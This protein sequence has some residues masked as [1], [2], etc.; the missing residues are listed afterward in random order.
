MQTE[1]LSLGCQRLW[2][3]GSASIDVETEFELQGSALLDMGS[4][5]LRS[6]GSA[7]LDMESL[8]QERLG[9]PLLHAVVLLLL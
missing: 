1:R 2:S 8:A 9:A 3:L 7:S 5:A 4:L 6:L